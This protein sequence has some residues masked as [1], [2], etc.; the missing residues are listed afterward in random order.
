MRIDGNQMFQVLVYEG[1]GGQKSSAAHQ[2]LGLLDDVLRVWTVAGH[3]SNAGSPSDLRRRTGGGAGRIVVTFGYRVTGGCGPR[4]ASNASSPSANGGSR[5]Q[6][7]DEDPGDDLDQ[8]PTALCP[9]PAVALDEPADL[10]RTRKPPTQPG[11]RHDQGH[12]R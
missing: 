12:A 7:D 9:V 10:G 11:L 4:D 8:P 2:V 6:H 3:G 5:G 1:P